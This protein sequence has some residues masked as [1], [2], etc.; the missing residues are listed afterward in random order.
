M[1]PFIAVINSAFKENNYW[2]SSVDRFLSL[3]KWKR[4]ECKM[5]SFS[6]LSLPLATA[7]SILLHFSLCL[8]RWPSAQTRVYF[9]LTFS[10]L[11]ARANVLNGDRFD[12]LLRVGSS[13]GRNRCQSLMLTNPLNYRPSAFSCFG[14]QTNKKCSCA[15]PSKGIFALLRLVW[16]RTSKLIGLASAPVPSSLNLQPIDRLCCRRSRH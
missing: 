15:P 1:H 8:A 6:R 2:K 16:N 10:T 9:V 7:V 4:A 11:L 14:A 12:M 3:F 5:G 13:I